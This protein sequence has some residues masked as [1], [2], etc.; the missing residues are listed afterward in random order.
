MDLSGFV[1]A[2]STIT[3]IR[4]V[5]GTVLPYNWQ[6]CVSRMFIPDPNSFHPG[7]ASKNSRILTPKIF[8]QISNLS[9]KM[10]RVV[11]P[12]FGSRIRK[13]IFYPSR[14]QGSRSLPFR[15]RN[16]ALQVYYVGNICPDLYPYNVKLIFSFF[17]FARA[18]SRWR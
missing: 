2:A 14:I 13:L 12:G 4:W 5:P 3:R 11:H 17:N 15:V 7:S 8:L 10:I 6:C 9:K 18:I 1:T 16:T